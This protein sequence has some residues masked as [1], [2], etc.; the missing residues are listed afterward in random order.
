MSFSKALKSIG[1]TICNVFRSSKD[2]KQREEQALAKKSMVEDSVN[3][4]LAELNLKFELSIASTTSSSSPMMATIGTNGQ[5]PLF[6]SKWAPRSRILS[7]LSTEAQRQEII[8]ELAQVSELKLVSQHLKTFAE[9][10]LDCHLFMGQSPKN[11]SRFYNVVAIHRLKAVNEELAQLRA[12]KLVSSL[13]KYVVK[14]S[15]VLSSSWVCLGHEEETIDSSSHQ[16]ECYKI[17]DAFNEQKVR[18]DELM[19]KM[20]KYY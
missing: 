1:K 11:S 20:L 10:K 15:T 17:L 19:N 9:G 7:A 8:E 2:K 12:L 13:Q 5:S 18:E 4:Q 3:Q 14:A 16:A 6:Q